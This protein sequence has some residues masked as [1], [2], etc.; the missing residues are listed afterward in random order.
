MKK[1]EHKTID[2]LSKDGTELEEFFAHST[3][4]TEGYE[5]ITILPFQKVLKNAFNMNTQQ[6][7]EMHLLLIFKK[8]IECQE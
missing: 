1:F 2:L 8:E 6:V 3:D 4:G 5:L 7:V